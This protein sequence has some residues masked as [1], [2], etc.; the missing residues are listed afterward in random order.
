MNGQP[1]VEKRV[2]HGAVIVR[3]GQWAIAVVAVLATL[4][5][6]AMFGQRQRTFEPWSLG[7]PTGEIVRL[8]AGQSVSQTIEVPGGGVGGF[9]AVVRAF[10][11]DT[12][13]VA[14]NLRIRR[15]GATRE[16]LRESVAVV[17][18]GG[19]STI[20][21][22]Q[23]S[24]VDTRSAGKLDFE[25]EVASTSQGEL[26]ILAS[27]TKNIGPGLLTINGAPTDSELRAEI[28]PI[29]S[30]G[31][32]GMLRMTS[33]GGMARVAG[34]VLALGLLSVVAAGL[35]MRTFK[36]LFE[37]D[38]PRMIDG[39]TVVLGVPLLTLTLV[40][41]TATM[42]VGDSQMYLDEIRD[43]FWRAAFA[44]PLLAL[45]VGSFTIWLPTLG[46]KVVAQTRNG[47]AGP[48]QIWQS[49]R[50]HPWRFLGRPIHQWRVMVGAALWLIILALVLDLWRVDGFTQVVAGVAEI[51]MGGAVVA[52]MLAS[53]GGRLAASGAGV[54]QRAI[55]VSGVVVSVGIFAL[56][57][58]FV[59][60]AIDDSV[61][62][63]IQRLVDRLS[64]RG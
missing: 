30:V 29:L 14:I 56:V 31:P 7:D 10:P 11:R 48:R 2:I 28:T 64:S 57:L 45:L 46:R 9:S 55:V 12:N 19:H 53:S 23:L 38:P 40:Q 22:G 6:V 5:I 49:A 63:L 33:L 32:V 58:F 54:N 43:G 15:S 62:V 8:Q 50:A 17:S 13:P 60:T 25:I 36:K 26:A 44:F 18:E 1:S 20:S 35:V 59:S 34:Y 16:I 42:V 52:A 39:P 61:V 4:G 27:R 3:F 51:V 21:T 47:R 41:A 37:V 24:P